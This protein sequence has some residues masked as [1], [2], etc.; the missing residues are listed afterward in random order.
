MNMNISPVAKELLDAIKNYIEES[1]KV[2][3][4]FE[5][6]EQYA[7]ERNIRILNNHIDDLIKYELNKID[8]INNEKGE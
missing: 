6:D 4:R 1:G 2:G 7:L 8:K 5:I 3:Y